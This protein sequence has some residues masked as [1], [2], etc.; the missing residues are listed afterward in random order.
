ML[1]LLFA[2]RGNDTFF[3]PLFF[4]KHGR[5][6]YFFLREDFELSKTKTL[7][8][9]FSFLLVYSKVHQHVHIFAHSTI[10][11]PFGAFIVTLASPLIIFQNVPVPLPLGIH[12]GFLRSSTAG[13]LLLFVL[14]RLRSIK[15]HHHMQEAFFRTDT[16]FFLDFNLPQSVV[17]CARLMICPL[18]C[19]NVILNFKIYEEDDE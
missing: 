14:L 10:L 2:S 19:C 16:Y 13:A 15:S 9:F 8:C 12:R 7:V 5:N 11:R 17:I 6:M 3:D 18:S 1:L 4:G